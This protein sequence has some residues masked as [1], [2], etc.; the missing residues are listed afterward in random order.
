M[1]QTQQQEALSAEELIAQDVGAR[2]PVGPMSWIIAGLALI[3]S[4]F[5]LWIAS[6]LPFSLGIGVLNDTETR[7]IHLAFAI[8]LAYLVFPAMRSSP[9]D[10]V[11][12]ADIALGLVG[13]AVASYLFV[14][15]QELAQRPGNLTT[16][17]FAVACVGI[18][19]LLE[20]AR[21]ALGP[22]LAVIAIVF[23]AYSLAGP[24]MPSLLAHR[25]VSLHALANHQWIT[26]EGVFGIALGVS[27]SFVFLFV[28]FGALLE[29]AGAG[30]YF[31]QLAFSLLGHLRG[32]PAKAAVVASAL[33]G[34]IS[35]SSIANVVTT[36]TFTIPMM[37]RVGFSK[38][39]AGAVE[40]ASSVNGQIMPPVMGAAAFLMV[41]YVGI[42]YVEIIKHAF[43]PA[44]ISYIAL[45]YIVHLE[46]LKL[47]MQ[48]IGNRQPRPWLRRLTGFAFGA[49]LISGLSMA[50]YYGLGWL[51][52]VL[53]D[54][55][56]PGISVLLAV[57]YL[58]LLKIAASNA[59]LPA[60]DPDKPLDELPETRAVLL[61]GL[62]FLLPVVVLV[63]CLMVERLSPGLS[64]FWGSVMLII[65][66]L[67]QRPLLNWLRTDGKHDYGS[68]TD[69]VVDLREGLIAGA[70]NMIGIGIAT[71]TAGIIVGAVSQTGVGLVLADL[72]EYLS[73]GNL[74][75]MLILTALLSLILGM[76]LPTTAN[77][78]VVSSLLAPVVVTLG[79]QNGLIVP[80]IA[81]HLF[82]FYFG[83][84]ADVTPPVGLASFAAA[85]VS[86]GDPIKTGITAFYYSL[87]TA[88]LPFLF[89]FNTDLLLI[90]V[91]FAHGVLIFI[92]ATIA[93]L[94]FAAATQGFFLVKSRWYESVLLLLVA[95]TLFRP[96]FW[97]D[98]L[99]DPYRDA[100]PA[101]LAQTMGQVEAE[102]TLR[103][104]MEGEDAV[105][106]LRRFTV[107]LPVPE[108]AS[109]EDRLAKLGIQTYEQDGKILIDTVT[110]GSQAADLGLEM[111]QQILSV[112]APTERWPKELMWLPGFLLFGA[113]V[114]LQRRRV[115]RP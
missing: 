33:T 19:L 113:V 53:G 55:A 107:L 3:W 40:V 32:G 101:E 83:I 86:K 25:G 20:A 22:A 90:N 92:V 87:R 43:L 72:V 12:L 28:L 79:Q 56:L 27:T 78:I 17:D 65:I 61:S 37:K 66:L 99:H 10:R 75:L 60:E 7:S 84:M 8:L 26:T 39:K 48:P 47:G 73:M 45:L 112:K 30:H 38:E 104:R 36:G 59:P 81:V 80:L 74:L 97:M 1:Q 41:E 103:L 42:P 14:M 63:W 6:P 9:R 114:W 102:S 115:A 111:D 52:P 67:T 21:R 57:A 2:L 89:I 76:G 18:P 13:A 85:A 51:K 64:A 69:G 46:A 91:D 106:K 82:V 93:M 58:G 44:A 88:A 62:H 34:V 15:Y 4:L 68:F 105:G 5:Q 70:R 98:M 71:A 35:G 50:V 96:G 94:I 16:M 110:F 29:R 95:F 24:W 54:Y 100:A 49:A 11:P 77:Y 108:G 31:I 109:G 23:L